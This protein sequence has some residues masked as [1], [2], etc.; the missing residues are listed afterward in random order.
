MKSLCPFLWFHDGFFRTFFARR[1]AMNLSHRLFS[2]IFCMYAPIDIA[3]INNANDKLCPFLDVRAD[4]HSEREKV[5]SNL[6][7]RLCIETLLSALSHINSSN[8]KSLWMEMGALIYVFVFAFM[9]YWPKTISDSVEGTAKNFYNNC[10]NEIGNVWIRKGINEKGRKVCVRACQCERVYMRLWSVRLMMT[11]MMGWR[12]RDKPTTEYTRQKRHI[13]TWHMQHTPK[14]GQRA[15]NTI[16]RDWYT[17]TFDLTR[18][19]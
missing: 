12:V 7:N 4:L 16:Y 19:I 1:C 2:P 9:R 5:C 11:M 14:C 15:T 8:V 13:K 10:R 17:G 6:D 3:S 18:E